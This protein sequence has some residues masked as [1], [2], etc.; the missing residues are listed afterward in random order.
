MQSGMLNIK[1][2]QV[3]CKKEKDFYVVAS[4]F[5]KKKILT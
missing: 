2:N 3:L 1:P 5:G 4:F